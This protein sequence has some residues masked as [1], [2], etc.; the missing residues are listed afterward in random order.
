MLPRERQQRLKRMIR[1]RGYLKVAELSRTFG[2]SEMTIHRDIRRLEAE[3]WVVK[4]HGGVAWAE[5]GESAGAARAEADRCIYC[6][7][8]VDRRHAYRLILKGGRVESACCAHCGLLR[9]HQLDGQVEHA[10]CQDFLR[11]TTISAGQAWYLVESDMD[12]GCCQ[13]QVLCFQACSDAERFR[14]GFGG[15]LL[16]FEEALNALTETGA[17]A[18]EGDAVGRRWRDS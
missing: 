6:L 8:P 7:R 3:G 14:Q 9:L 11:G 15:R 18:G 4:T 10:L 5:E 2:V 12:I 1:E 13:P 17:H 16:T